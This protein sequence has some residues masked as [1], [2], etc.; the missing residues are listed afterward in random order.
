MFFLVIEIGVPLLPPAGVLIMKLVRDKRIVG[1]SE[2]YWILLL[3]G[4]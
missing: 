4:G 2:I 1:F 3:S